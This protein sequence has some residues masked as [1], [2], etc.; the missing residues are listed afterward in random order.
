MAQ[1]YVC[2]MHPN[3]SSSGPGN[4]PECGMA[5]LAEGTRFALLRHMLTPLHLSIM[6]GVMIVIMAV[7]MMIG[8]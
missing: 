6:A 7:V 5:L 8:S 1:S 3:V 2:P 4:C